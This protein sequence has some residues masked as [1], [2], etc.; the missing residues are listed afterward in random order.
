MNLGHKTAE[1]DNGGLNSKTC[2]LCK[3]NKK[4]Y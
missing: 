4:T 3:K 2:G 1:P